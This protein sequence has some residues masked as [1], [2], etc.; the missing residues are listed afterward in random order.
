[1]KALDIDDSLAEPHAC[2]GLGKSYYDW[3][4]TGAE[5]EFLHAIELN[6]NSSTAHYW[7]TIPLVATAR[8][9][10]AIAY[11]RRA[12]EIEPLSLVVH[13][14]LAGALT[15]AG[16]YDEAI[17]AGRKA[18]ELDPGFPL[19]RWALT[20]AYQ[21]KGMHTEVIVELQ[22]A[23]RLSGGSPLVLGWLGRAY[24]ISGQRDE[25]HKALRELEQQSKRRYVAP[26]NL[27]L[28][29]L[30]LGET[31]RAFEWLEKSREDR[32]FWLVYL[33]RFAP[34]FEGVRSDPRYQDLLRRMNLAP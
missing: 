14:N 5:R 12:V 11:A 24:G 33:I 30:G 31:E 21:Q 1:M 26:F 23:F 7:F 25:A 8:V 18:I 22:E 20:L 32:S 28:V 6:P 19:A 9:D 4:W 34:L 17:E 13:T 15:A 29:Y 2:L 16:R 3:D 27:A 10:E